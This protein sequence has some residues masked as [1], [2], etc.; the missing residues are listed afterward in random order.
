MTT[1]KLMPNPGPSA[2]LKSPRAFKVLA[3]IASLGWMTAPAA[4][5]AP[6]VQEKL[7]SA[8]F[9][10]VLAKPTDDPLT[11][12]KPLPLELL[13]YRERTDLYRSIGT[14]FAIGQNQFVTAAHVLS[15]G[16]S[17]QYGPLALR[18]AGGKIYPVDKVLKFSASEDYAVFSVHTPPKLVPLLTRSRPPLNT[19]VFA[20][21]N[22][23]GEGVVVR[24][25]LYTSDTPEE[26]D[27]RWQWLRFS[28]AASPGNSGGPLID[29]TGKVVGIV[30]RKSPNENLNFA[31]AVAQ[32]LAGSETAGVIETRSSYRI[33]VMRATDSVRRNDS[34]ALPKT[35]EE[36]YASL[37]QSNS[38]WMSTIHTEFMKNHADTIFP[39]GD[40]LQLL[41]SVYAEAFPRLIHQSDG[42]TWTVEGETPKKVQLD[43]NGYFQELVSSGVLLA[44]LRAPD[45]VSPGEFVA[46]SKKIMDLILKAKPFVRQVGSDA[47]RITSMG[48]ANT[49]RWDIDRYGRKWLIRTWLLPFSDSVV[50]IAGFPTPDGMVMMMLQ[51]PTVAREI[52]ESEML[53]LRGFFYMSYTGSLA[54]WRSF[55]ADETVLP[56]AVL[57]TKVQFD[58]SRGFGVKTSRFEMLVPTGVVRLDG[59]SVLMLKF[60]YMKKDADAVWDLGGVYL[61]EN[62]Q[63]TKWIG[64]L[65]RVRPAPSLPEEMERH[66]QEM[67]KEMHPWEGIPFLAGGRTEINAMM[68]AKAVAAGKNVGYTITLNSEGSQLVNKVKA[69]FSALERG[70]TTAE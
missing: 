9:E 28:A 70:F 68:N 13:P 60:S 30:L 54:Q 17:S 45:D 33:G 40:S 37:H 55:L 4:T 59:Q 69:E 58:Y 15:A 46:D 6:G 34:I 16:N 56:T 62:V 25:G 57:N 47:V 63:G 67:T 12:E 10:V 36:F 32:V 22:A 20:V 35:L 52:A 66:W 1:P 51:E 26:L 8:T 43:K 7:T 50:T 61:S 3:L 19:P 5:L 18:D 64:T 42:G 27:G 29:R 48:R 49:E 21:G 65:R 23:Y 41:S 44:R 11:Y 2:N 39:A 31:L 53:A 24:D 14:A 38:A